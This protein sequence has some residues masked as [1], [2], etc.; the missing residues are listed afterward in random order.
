MHRVSTFLISESRRIDETTLAASSALVSSESSPASTSKRSTPASP[1][2]GEERGG[3]GGG[4]GGGEAF[5]VE[6]LQTEIGRTFRG[7]S[8]AFLR[9]PLAPAVEDE[10]CYAPAI[11]NTLAEEDHSYPLT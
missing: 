2:V 10:G 11:S 4:G 6:G 9:E 8:E 5:C 3:G 1:P 7:S